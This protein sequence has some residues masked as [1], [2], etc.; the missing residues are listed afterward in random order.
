MSKSQTNLRKSFKENKEKEIEIREK[1]DFIDEYLRKGAQPETTLFPEDIVIMKDNSANITDDDFTPN[2][3]PQS[4][5]FVNEKKTDHSVIKHVT[6][7]N[8]AYEV[9]K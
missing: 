4:P 1:L 8:E 9:M 2:K 3:G 7:I 5:I 6:H